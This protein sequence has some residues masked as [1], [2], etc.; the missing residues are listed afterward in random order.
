MKEHSRY[1]HYFLKSDNY[2]LIQQA[3]DDNKFNVFFIEPEEEL[4][5]KDIIKILNDHNNKVPH[6][7]R[8]IIFLNYTKT[9]RYLFQKEFNRYVITGV[10]KETITNI[11]TT[12]GIF[13]FKFL[14]EY[15]LKKE[16][17]KKEEEQQVKNGCNCRVCKEYNYWA[18]PDCVVSDSNYTCWN[19]ANSYH[20]I[21][22]GLDLENI[23]KQVAMIKKNY[24]MR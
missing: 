6:T 8:K 16:T 24:G 18:V 21:I 9:F 17:E 1:F 20:R 13:G 15:D 10:T 7:D 11:R 5:D 14:F 19:C 22:R 12:L 3:R 23:D 2:Y 4:I